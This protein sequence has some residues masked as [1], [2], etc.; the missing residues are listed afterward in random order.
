MIKYVYAE[1]DEDM[2]RYTESKIA[3]EAVKV[4][5]EYGELSMG[6][7]IEILIQRMQPTGH[8]IEI[9]ANR[10][11]S[12][13][14]QKVRNLRSHSNKIF[15]NNVYYDEVIDKYV[16]YE[17]KKM[18]VNLDEKV[19]V[20]ELGQKKNK[21]TIFYARKLD[22]ERINRERKLIGNA[23]EELV[24]KAQIKFVKECAP[25]YLKSVRHVSKLDGDGA[26][27]DICS[28]NA[29]KKLVYI[30]VK[31]TTGKKET[32][33]YMTST[34]Y[35]FFELHKDNYIIARVYEFDMNTKVGKIEYVSGTDF[36]G[37]FEKEVS[38]YKI[39]YKK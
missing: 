19:Y 32:P 27:Y 12:Y 24:Y 38:A 1:G 22:Y 37:V 7:L 15:F 17:C 6:E 9:I 5:E 20:E 31:S 23:G 13:F 33:F 10:N 29:D 21:A 4:V 26:G 3:V 2:S 8:D 18:K 11:D 16:S 25:E 34:E 35:A 36:E 14:S 39:I 28:F 30:E